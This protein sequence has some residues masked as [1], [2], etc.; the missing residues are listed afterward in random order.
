MTE[1]AG[2]DIDM[3]NMENIEENI[4]KKYLEENHSKFNSLISQLIGTL[5]LEK[6]EDEK[7]TQFEERLLNDIKKILNV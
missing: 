4:I 3:G 5:D 1:E 2:V 6:R 7:N